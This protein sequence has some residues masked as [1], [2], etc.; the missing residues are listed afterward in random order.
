MRFFLA[1]GELIC[2]LTG[3]PRD[4]DHRQVLRSFINTMVWGA[5]TTVLA[6]AILV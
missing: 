2:D 3:T 1:P 6:L 5:V 4:S